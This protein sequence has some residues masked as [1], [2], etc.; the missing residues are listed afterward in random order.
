[1]TAYEISL[2]SVQLNIALI[3]CLMSVKHRNNKNQISEQPTNPNNN[4][5]HHF[6]EKNEE[7]L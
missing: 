7:I 4:S 6:N 2:P 1:M 5:K 3:K